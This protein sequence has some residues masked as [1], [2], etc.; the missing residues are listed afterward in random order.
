MPLTIGQ[1]LKNAREER[2]I[3]IEKAAQETRIRSV[4]LQ[5]LENDDFS[6]MPSAAQGR[7][8]LR[9]YADY[10]GIN[11]DEVIAEMQ[12]ATP[13]PDEVSGPLPQVNLSETELP[14]LTSPDKT[15]EE[16]PRPAK[17]P[18]L[19]R[20]S[21][22]PRVEAAESTP[23]AESADSAAQA[24]S[25]STESITEPVA[26]T[27]PLKKRGRKKKQAEEEVIVPVPAPA[28]EVPVVVEATIPQE[29]IKEIKAG[30]E[31]QPVEAGQVEVEQEAKPSLL[32]RVLSLFRTRAAKPA[33]TPSSEVEENAEPLVESKPAAPSES[34]DAIFREI[35]RMLRERRELISLTVDEVERHT[36]LRAV[37]VVALEEGAVD[38]L[39]SPVQTRGMLANYATFLDL[40]V[41]AILLRFADG[42][43][44][45][46]REKYAE[47]PRD[48]IQTEVKASIPLLRGFIA[49]DLIFGF[50]MIAIILALAVWGVSR[51]FTLGSKPKIE[52]TAPS[53]VDVLAGTPLPTPSPE[54]FV[55][56]LE[57][58]IATGDATDAAVDA[59]P[60]LNVNA[61]VTVSIFAVERTFL[62][63]SVDGEVVF[64]GRIAP[65]ETQVYEAENQ[66]EVLTGNA[67]A[68]RI[69]YNGR[70]LGLMGNIGE[71]VSRIYLISGIA[72]P[73]ATIQP[74]PTNTPAV[75]D[76]PTPTVTPE[77]SPTPAP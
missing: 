75:T 27:E 8:F 72:T 31:I 56:V 58:P 41:D 26:E 64:E 3:T 14:P 35:G 73:T 2:Y 69:T 13:P 71:V 60:T 9:N 52:S 70:D 59:A 38:R 11:I 77:S 18:R 74:T 6:V 43:Q 24:E 44:A 29:E 68:L 51:A 12:R 46:R 54:A 20:T 32:T 7:G 45:R 65:R 49:G 36:R 5:A 62:R 63:V 16:K 37:F 33:V 19:K 21:K 34:A 47:T 61:N 30:E 17:K 22:L 55:P 25:P 67:A 4:F 15:E 76:T 53:I 39:P 1:R 48:K 50:V 28:L 10:L 23:E 57:A 42:L 66:V 40:D